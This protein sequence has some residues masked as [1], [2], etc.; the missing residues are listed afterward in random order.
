[1]SDRPSCLLTLKEVTTGLNVSHGTLYE[2]R[3]GTPT[4]PPLPAETI[5][6][7]AGIIIRIDECRLRDYLAEHRP[8]L[9]RRWQ[10][11]HAV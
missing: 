7:G 11:R 10:E 6:R 5:P 9:L 4:R 1:M 2:W 3:L 8:D